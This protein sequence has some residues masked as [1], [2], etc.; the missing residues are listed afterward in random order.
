MSPLVRPA[1]ARL[2]GILAVCLGQFGAGSPG[3]G[4]LGVQSWPG[5]CKSGGDGGMRRQ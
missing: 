5:E 2:L 1:L 3:T 4:R